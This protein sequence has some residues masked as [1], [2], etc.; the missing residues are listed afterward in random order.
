MK[1][2][3]GEAGA[4]R[5]KSVTGRAGVGRHCPASGVQVDDSIPPSIVVVHHPPC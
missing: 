3:L 5:R 1:L 2:A 4:R